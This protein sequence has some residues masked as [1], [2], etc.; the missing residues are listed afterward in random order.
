M[1]GFKY[2]LP[3]EFIE[4]L[5]PDIEAM[6]EK[7]VFSIVERNYEAVGWEAFKP[8][9]QLETNLLELFA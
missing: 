2:E 1:V 4:L 7:Q 5:P 9:E 6:F 3:T 8:N